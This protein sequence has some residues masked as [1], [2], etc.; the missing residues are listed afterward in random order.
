MRFRNLLIAVS[1]SAAVCVACLSAFAGADTSTGPV[2]FVKGLLMLQLQQENGL[3]IILP[4]AEAHHAT[5]T[6]VMKDG[7]RKSIPFKGHGTIATTRSG[8]APA[9]I[10]VP[11]LIRMRELFGDGVKPLVERAPNK[12]SI[13]WSSIQSVTTE[14]VSPYRY[15]FVRKDNGEEIETFRPRKISETIRIQL[16]SLGQLDI[17]P[18]KSD[19]DT[20]KVKEVWME[21]VPQ[22]ADSAAGDMFREHFH[23]LLQYINRPS[24]QSFDVEPRRLGA[25]TASRLG[26]AFW[27]DLFI[28]CG[29]VS[30]D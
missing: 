2:V 22:R 23:H 16:T 24:D 27:I 25:A 20:S 14:E 26:R 15:P 11:E 28:F 18:L 3:Q 30:L 1:V 29:P 7:T 21:Q 6:F 5:I 17:R 19:I 4:D 10:K 12:V 13:P 8:N 9:V